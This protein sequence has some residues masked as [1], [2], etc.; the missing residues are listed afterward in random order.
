MAIVLTGE[1]LR[2]AESIKNSLFQEFGLKGALRSPAHITL[3]RPFE[4]DEKKETRL[5][6]T[7]TEFSQTEPFSIELRGF[8]HFSNRV[9]F[10]DVLPNEHLLTLYESLRS[11]AHR[12]LLLFNESEDMRGFRPHVTLAF[13]DLR[14]KN[15]EPVWHYISNLSFRHIIH[16]E[17]FSLLRLE[18]K[19]CE[20]A[21][22]P[23]AR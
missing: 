2:Q 9:V 1:S 3:H 22:F 18:E 21:F 14:K 5:K 19:W 12:R 17:G 13:R 6:N 7:L 15:F 11:F 10:A 8:S 23:F 16:A 4:W 20:I